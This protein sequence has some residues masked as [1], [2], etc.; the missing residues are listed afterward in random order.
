MENA[1]EQQTQQRILS[2]IEPLRLCSPRGYLCRVA[3][4]YRYGTPRSLLKLAGIHG[5]LDL[6]LDD[7][8]A[9]I[10]HAL[11]LDREEWIALN[12]SRVEVPY[13]FNK[14]LFCGQI[15]DAGRLNY[16]TPRVCAE[17]LIETQVWWALWDLK[18]VCACP[19][20]AARLVDICSSCGQQL[21]WNRPAP[22]LCRCG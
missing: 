11:R 3:F 7:G 8:A 1:F 21:R 20:H 6:D 22:H 14:R 2:R 9:R 17:C 19:K 4:T 18:Y 5:L 13:G 16:G 12:Y 15:L 10:S